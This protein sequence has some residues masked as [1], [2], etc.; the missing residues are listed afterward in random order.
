MFENASLK[1]ASGGNEERKTTMGCRRIN[2]NKT[3]TQR[4][5]LLAAATTLHDAK[6]RMIGE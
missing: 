5:L 4:D 2:Q 1:G 6:D 3:G